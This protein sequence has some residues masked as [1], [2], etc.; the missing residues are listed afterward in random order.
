MWCTCRG[1]LQHWWP[2]SPRGSLQGGAPGSLLSAPC[3][4]FQGPL[5][6]TEEKEEMYTALSKKVAASR[7]WP[8][9]YNQLKLNAIPCTVLTGPSSVQKWDGLASG[10][11]AGCGL[12][13][14]GAVLSG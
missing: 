4:L 6:R 8:R 14:A 1:S 2:A 13:V 3:L 10:S 5:R 9:E 11:S 7:V 12:P